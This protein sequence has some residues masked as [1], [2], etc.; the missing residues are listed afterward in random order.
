MKKDFIAHVKQNEDGSWKEPHYLNDHL[1]DVAN[2]AGKFAEEF[3]NRDWAELAGYLHD[4]GKYNPDWQK[5]LFRNSGYPDPDA[6]IEN[7]GTRPNHS[8]AGSVYIFEK[9]KKSKMANALA[10]AIGGHHSG[11]PDWTPQLYQRLFDENGNLIIDDLEKIKPI[12]EAKPFLESPIPT[13][14]PA[15]YKCGNSKEAIEQNHLWIRM[16]FSCLVDADFLDTEKYMEEKV[17]GD[18]LPIS[19]LQKKLDDYLYSKQSESELN[20]KRN[21]ILKQCIDKAKLEP[22]FFSLTVPTGGGKTLSS[23]AFALKHAIK[24]DKKRVI[25]AIP[26]TS[27]IEQTS[28][29]FKYGSDIDEEIEKFKSEGKFLFGEDQVVEH[30][31]N[32]D[33]E[34]EN[35]NN[36]LAKENWDAPI[37]VTTNVQLFES[38]FANRTSA[39]R[40]LH[41]IANSIII[42][43]EAQMIP[44]DYLKPIIS[45]LN[46]LVKF[47]GVTVLLMSATQ[48]AL[49]GKIGSDTSVID[50]LE[51][52]TEIIDD[53]DSLALEFKRVKVEIP[54]DLTE[55]QSYEEIAE[56]LKSYHRVL[57][58]V[59][60][61]DDCRQIHKQM[62]EGT[63]HLSGYMCGEER[64]E[65]ISDIK[66]KLK[67]NESIRVISTQIVEAGVDID[68]PVVYR[69]LSGLDSIAQAAGRCN[70]ENKIKDGGKVTVFNPPKPSPVGFLRKAED[71]GKAVI[72]N[73]TNLE[74]IP[75]IYSEYYKYLY[76]N[77]ITFD[78]AD[79]QHYILNDTSD[80]HFSFKTFAQKF[81]MI[82][83]TKQYSIIVWYESKKSKIDSRDLIKQLRYNPT[84]E[85]LRKLQRYVVNVPIYI[86]NNI[87]NANYVEDIN[88]YWVQ[89]DEN[90]YKPGLGLLGNESDWIIGDGV[91]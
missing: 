13:S 26:Y 76:S 62:P 23:M 72:R 83:S 88:G 6:H 9:F 70:R 36:R 16:L 54:K 42:L 22:G 89:C 41:N 84:K 39:C 14:I 2:L 91:V 8:T 46:G 90:L 30:H 27:I 33:P 75:S 61:K 81:N 1:K 37:I 51:K 69:A 67:N 79:F 25:V 65:V 57:C 47:F 64:S 68:F 58:I 12:K 45:V 80:F 55:R 44:T 20:K 19:E 17:R 63:I 40:K 86:F 87:K 74:L 35:H 82:D 11:L 60:R 53:P 48:P 31:S 78:K 59:N 56:Q 28:K 49:K 52:V 38:L 43:D 15:N 29:V 18:Y 5:Y 73:K 7:L 71:A 66:S 21:K 24:H 3:K 4:L 32:L 85:L 10:Y 77:L 50:G 34:D